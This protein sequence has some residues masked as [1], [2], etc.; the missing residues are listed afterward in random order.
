MGGGGGGSF[1][2]TST[3]GSVT[4]AGSDFS[5][6]K[7]YRT[8]VEHFEDFLDLNNIQTGTWFFSTGSR[9]N[10]E[11]ANGG[12]APGIL[13][14]E[15]PSSGTTEAR[16]A[17]VI[18]FGAGETI[19]EARV[20]IVTL[21]TAGEDFVVSVGMM[22]NNTDQNNNYG[23]WFLF[24]RTLSTTKWYVRNTVTTSSNKTDSDTGITCTANTWYR[25]RAVINAGATSIG[26]YIDDVLV[27]TH[28]TT[29]PTGSTG[30][31]YNSFCVRRVAGTTA[32]IF[33]D[34]DYYYW[35]QSFTTPR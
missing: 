3:D 20:R 24:D 33:T 15:A 30:A 6:L 11:T 35:K 2:P 7:K 12:N 16:Q 26:Y 18:V 13:R 25:L 19:F 17:R 29:I 4:I 10:A 1:S 5:A 8:F 23:S 14:Y 31:C 32:S 21:P 22:S 28:T 27:A 9:K 34:M